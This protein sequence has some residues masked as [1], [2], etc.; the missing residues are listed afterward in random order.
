M[1]CEHYKLPNNVALCLIVFTSKSLLSAEQYYNNIEC[2]ALGILHGLEKFHHYHF[3]WEVCIITDHKPLA[4]ILSKDVA[5]DIVPVFA[6][7]KSVWGIHYIQARPRSLHHMLAVKEQP[8]RR[9]RPGNHRHEHKCE[10]HQPSSKYTSLH[11][12]KRHTVGNM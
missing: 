5:N 9:P 11:I 2:K 7:H 8:Y 3:A 12:D 4:V 6:A 10:C 1:N